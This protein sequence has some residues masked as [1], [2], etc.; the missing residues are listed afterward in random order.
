MKIIGE[1]VLR[2]IGEDVV[3]VPTGDTALQFNGMILLN[4]VS[5]VLWERLTEG[6]DLSALVTAIT[7]QFDV[8]PEEA[9][10]DIEEFLAALEQAGLLEE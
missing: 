1:F 7:A 6:C 3:V 10:A 2:Q 4:A 9:T 5:R 8:T